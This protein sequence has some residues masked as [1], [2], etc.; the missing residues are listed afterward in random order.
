MI[1]QLQ[2]KPC[3][4]SIWYLYCKCLI[5]PAWYNGN[6]N[7]SV[8]K[9]RNSSALAIELRMFCIKSQIFNIFLP[10]QRWFLW[11]IPAYDRSVHQ[12]TVG[13]NSGYGI[14]KLGVILHC[15]VVSHLQS[16]YPKCTMGGK[17]RCLNMRYHEVYWIIRWLFQ[18]SLFCDSLS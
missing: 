11:I 18:G 5:K 14:S 15:N 2:T 13:N 10:E 8:G 16:P 6:E 3:A 1:Q 12:I 17:I 4:Y 7:I 9:I